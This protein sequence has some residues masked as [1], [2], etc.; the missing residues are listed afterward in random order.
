MRAG[1]VVG[2]TLKGQGSGFFMEISTSSGQ[3]AFLAKAR[4]TEPR[5]FGCPNSALIV[6]R[7]KVAQLAQYPDMGRQGRVCPN[8][9][10][11]SLRIRVASF[12]IACSLKLARSTFDVLGK[13]H[14]T[15][16]NSAAD[17]YALKRRL[18]APRADSRRFIL[19]LAYVQS[20]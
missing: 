16:R 20:T 19:R 9:C 6:L 1:G 7:D 8:G 13:R 17:N 10:E 14:D 2:V 4:S 15:G 11:N 18:S 5:R 12:F 3:D